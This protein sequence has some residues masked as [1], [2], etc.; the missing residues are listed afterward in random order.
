MIV[1]PIPEHR[2]E[3]RHTTRRVFGGEQWGLHPS[4][5]VAQHEDAVRVDPSCFDQGVI[6]GAKSVQ[7]SGEVD[8]SAGSAAFAITDVRLL[9]PI[10]CNPTRDQFLPKPAVGMGRCGRL[11]GSA[12]IAGYQE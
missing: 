5:R 8:I 9:D 1:S 2:A 6:T 3:R 10:I 11:Y 12:R 7:L 4:K